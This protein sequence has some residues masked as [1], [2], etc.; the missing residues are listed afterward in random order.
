MSYEIYKSV[1][2]LKDGTFE[3]VSASS[4]ETDINGNRPFKKWVMDYYNKEYPEQSNKIKRALLTLDSTYDGSFFYSANWKQD[5]KLARQF[6][7]D[8]SY[9]WHVSHENKSLW[10]EYAKEFICYKAEKH[11]GKKKSFIVKINS[12]YV[13]RKTARRCFLTPFEKYAKVFKAYDITE[14]EKMFSGYKYGTNT[15]TVL[16]QEKG[17]TI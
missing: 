11:S 3:C 7:N 8:N 13:D 10:I 14:I 12:D 5:Q 2:Q 4:N 9:D 15:V 17:E 6:M 1:K 16:E